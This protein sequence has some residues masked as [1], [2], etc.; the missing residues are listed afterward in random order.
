MKP[1][2]TPDECLH[3]LRIYGCSDSVINHCLAVRD[4]AVK[5]ASYTDANIAL[6]EVGAL[7]HDIGRGKTHGITHAIEG[8]DI[9]RSLDLPPEIVNIIERHLGAGIPKQEAVTIGL[10]DKDYLPVT[11]E[12]KI[13]THAD[14][15]IEDNKKVPISLEIKKAENKQKYSYAKRL[16]LLHDELSQICGIDLDEL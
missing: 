7:L 16:R 14:N 1:L 8:A 2:P 11:L 10:P 9:A 5:I 12:E 3:L 15:L 6:V 4:L 13:V